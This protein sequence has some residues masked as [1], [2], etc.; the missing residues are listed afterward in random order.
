MSRH[1]AIPAA[2]PHLSL[3]ILI[4]PSPSSEERNGEYE[5]SS[6]LGAIASTVKQRL[7]RTSARQA[8]EI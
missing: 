5:K 3:S 4:R 8:Q 7:V 1:A 2:Q 6:L